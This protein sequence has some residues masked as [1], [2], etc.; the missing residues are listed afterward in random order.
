MR[1]R[2]VRVRRAP[3]GKLVDV[4]SAEAPT[5]LGHDVTGSVLERYPPGHEKAGEYVTRRAVC[6]CCVRSVVDDETGEVLDE[7]PTYFVQ[8]KLSERFLRLA[9]KQAEHEAE[10]YGIAT[11]AAVDRPSPI[12]LPDGWT[13][14]ACPSCARSARP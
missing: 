9:R 3:S 6:P 12:G 8:S 13:P 7:G 1:T 10:K 5:E 2:V 14:D 4:R 11:T